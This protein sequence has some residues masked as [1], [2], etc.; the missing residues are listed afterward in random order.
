MRQEDE[1]LIHQLAL[2]RN[3]TPKTENLYRITL[4]KYSKFCNKSLCELL[5]EAENEEDDKIAWRKRTLRKR[6]I[7]F[8]HYLY[9]RYMLSTAKMEFSKILTFYKHFE[10]EL[11]DLPV[12]SEKAGKN[13]IQFSDLPDKD[14]LRDALKVAAPLHKAIILFQVSTGCAAAETLNLKVSDFIKSVSEYTDS[15]DIH[16]IIEELKD[17]KNV[18]PMFELRRQKTGKVFYTFATPEAFHTICYY[19]MKRKS[20][21]DTD[22]VFKVTQLHLMQVFREINDLLGLGTIGPNNFVRFRSHMLRKFHASALYNDGMSMEDVNALQ[23]KSKTRTDQSYFMEDPS[24][25]KMK[26]IEHMGAVTINWEVNS[27][28]IQS[29]EYRRLE[30]Q[31][32]NT[33][34]EYES[35]KNRVRNIEEALSNNIS[36]DDLEVLHKYI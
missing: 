21:L 15:T 23:G 36:K 26:Y 22:R 27:L 2:D 28:N 32:I 10:I 16:T 4:N 18:V 13:V 5:E 8:R 7:S 17:D 9:E 24:K 35:L 19:L 14:I 25:L 33:E 11:H 6:L 20:L 34:A 12:I 29:E 30:K 31:L 3:I 1:D